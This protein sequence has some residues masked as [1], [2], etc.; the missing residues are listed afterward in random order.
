MYQ[1]FNNTPTPMSTI[2]PQ[3]TDKPVTE[4]KAKRKKI[5][6]RPV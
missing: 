1:D 6:K 2:Q 5:I 3:T 4:E